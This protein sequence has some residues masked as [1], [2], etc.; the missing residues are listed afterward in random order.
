MDSKQTMAE[1]KTC[2]NPGCDQPGTKSCASCK[3]T[4]YCCVICQTTDWPSHKEMCDGHLR[5]I[6]KAN[7]NKA[8]GFSREQNLVQELFYAEIAA[9]K[10]K[11]LKDRRLETVEVIDEALGFKCNALL[12]MGR[13]SEAMKCAEE[14]YTLWAMN[15]MRNPGSMKAAL[16][17]IH[18]CIHNEKFEDAEFY[19]REAY[20]MINDMADNFI[21]ADERP[22]FLAEVSSCLAQSITKKLAEVKD[23][24]LEEKKK[25]GEEAI[26]LA[27]KALEIR[28]QLRGAT[29]GKYANSQVAYMMGA[30]ADTLDYFN[31]VDDDEPIRLKEQAIA[32]YSQAD[33]SSSINVGSRNNNLG[34]AYN[35]RAERAQAANDLDRELTNLE[36]ALTHY[37][38]GLRIY[39]INNHADRTSDALNNIAAVEKKIRRVVFAKAAAAAAASRR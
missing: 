24:P 1:V 13:H 10:L 2:A 5:K 31:N 9:T 38:E 37:R 32:I 29:T 27:R 39:R 8:R 30:L 35:N 7:L 3:I 18:S 4:V 34:Y 17:L 23:I 19:S 25:A 20:F 36:L 28:I 21:P 14:N 12:R 6:G 16:Q 22:S 15:Q 11:Q 26:T 33:G